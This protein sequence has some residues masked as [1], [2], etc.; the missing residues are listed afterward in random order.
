MD[1]AHQQHLIEQLIPLLREK[2]FEEIF[3]RLTQ[4]ENSNSRFLIKMELKRKC[5]PC[6]RIID[7]RDELEDECQVHEFEGITHFMPAEAAGLFQSQCYLY[8]DIYTL[9]VYEAMQQWLRQHH[10]RS[11][12]QLTPPA[13]PFRQYDVNTISFASYY[14]RR[15]ERM[16][17]SSP[18][19]IKFQDGEKLFAKSSD[20]SLGGM[21]VSVPY[22]PNYLT[23]AQVEVFFTGL[24]RDNPNPV[25]HQPVSYQILGEESKEGK[26][27]LR[28]VRTGEHSAFNTFLEEFIEAN[29]ARYRVS[30]DY[31]LSAAIIKGY[32]QFYLPRMTGMPLFFGKGDSPSLEIALRT[33]NNQHLLEYWRDEKN[34]DTLASLFYAERMKQLCP[35]SGST[36]ETLIYAFTHTVR[37][38]IYFFSASAEELQQSGLKSLFFQVGSRRP[39]W[40]VY[41]FTLEACDLVEA[42]IGQLQGQDNPQLQDILLTERLKQIGYVGLLQDI[43]QESQRDE[44]RPQ[45][46][47]NE[48]AN[49][50]HCYAHD[51]K[52]APFEIETLHYVQLRK[53]LRYIHKT[54]V[55]IH[56]KGKSWLGWTR[57]ISTHGLQIE[58]EEAFD[59]EKNDVVTIALPRLQELSKSMDLQRLSYRL[60]SLNTTR[61]VLHLC[62]EGDS[63]RHT[64]RQFFSLLIESNQNKLKAAQEQRRYRGLA[65]ALRNIYTHHL[66]N[67]PVY[68]NKLKGAPKPASIG[69]S[70]QPR[71]LHQLLEACAELPDQDNLYPLFQGGLLKELLMN[72]L[73]AIEREDKPKEDEVYIACEQTNTGLP[74]FD[75]RLA[76]SFTNAQEK[77]AFIELAL[78]RGEFY[79]VLVG[80]SRTGRPD[81]NFIANELDYIA[82]FAIHKARKLEEE[83]WS[84][85]GVGELTDTTRATLFRLGIAPPSH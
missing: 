55:A 26:Y 23:G 85:V 30:V 69:K 79:S 15:Q 82:K 33:E 72:P 38:H 36:S 22:L 50:L 8:R 60:V 35:P 6:R 10:A 70:L 40:R 73:R 4:E 52:A 64:G 7:M 17:F 42:D 41:K 24:E 43:T 45:E 11:D 58:L 3:N 61:T 29:K 62:I 77:R 46:T 44:F 18:L 19:L 51:Q 21:R 9:G 66:F 74:V 16:H 67:S 63:D 71:S 83:L 84:V 81:T 48:N 12:S 31:L 47:L 5:S 25:L 57:D 68:I 1:S 53:E 80:I 27:W 20:L 13:S 37:S 65:R 78:K 28:L 49:E 14:G 54:A 39:S 76:S 2:D 56:H 75:S 32:E 34:R 59:G